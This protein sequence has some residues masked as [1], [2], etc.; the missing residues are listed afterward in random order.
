MDGT[1][2]SPEYIRQVHRNWYLPGTAVFMRCEIKFSL[3]EMKGKEVRWRP[4]VGDSKYTMLY[5][6]ASK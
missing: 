3:L 6:Y 1:F 4:G 2:F 5:M